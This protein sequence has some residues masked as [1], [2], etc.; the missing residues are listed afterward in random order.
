MIKREG[1]SFIP[2][3]NTILM[4]GDRVILYTQINLQ[5]DAHYYV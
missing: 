1:K 4:E 2:N 5:S 3:G